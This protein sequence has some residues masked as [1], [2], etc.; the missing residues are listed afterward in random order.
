MSTNQEIALS[1]VI[2]T[3]DRYDRLRKTIEHL[4]RQ[5]AKNCIELVIAAPSLRELQPDRAELSDFGSVRLV[6]VGPIQCT[7]EPRAIATR[8]AT[9]PVIAYAE[10]HC[11]PEPNWAAA[12]IKAHRESWGGVGARKRTARL[13]LPVTKA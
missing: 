3:P 4:R 6:E 7:G 5:T 12:L 13:Y 11:W 9:G 2:V 10:D 1:I 8:A